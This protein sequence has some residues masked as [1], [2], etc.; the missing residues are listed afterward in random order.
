M[1]KKILVA[2]DDENVRQSHLFALEAASDILKIPFDVAQADNSVAALQ[3]IRTQHFDLI[4][5]DND[6]KDKD[7]PGHLPGIALLQLARKDSP[8]QHTPVVFCSAETFET[9]APMVERY[10]GVV[11]PKA[12][13]DLTKS[14]RLFAD[15]LSQSINPLP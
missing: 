9:L 6:F 15:L 4:L 10:H 3:K 8:N 14:A 13:L 12:D 7:I 2:D 11:F 5:I 1:S